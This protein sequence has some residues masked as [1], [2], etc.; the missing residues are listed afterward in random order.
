MSRY[1][2]RE[3]EHTARA[4]MGVH[5]NLALEHDQ[6]FNASPLGARARLFEPGSGGPGRRRLR[7]RPGIRARA[8]STISI[9]AA[10]A[11]NDSGQVREQ[12]SSEMW[13]EVNCLFHES[14]RIGTPE[15]I[16]ARGY[17]MVFAVAAKLAPVPGH[18]RFP[19]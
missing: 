12:I 16:S 7:H 14:K 18:Y 3:A 19:P 17:D 10:R 8:K 11:E 15:F 6:G 4:V 9:A 1:L 5:W 13:E 2:E